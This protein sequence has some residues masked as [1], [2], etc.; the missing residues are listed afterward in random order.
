VDTRCRFLVICVVEQELRRISN[1]A[2]L[3]TTLYG[4]PEY[5]TRQAYQQIRVQTIYIR[6]GII[7]SYKKTANIMRAWLEYTARSSERCAS[8][9]MKRHSAI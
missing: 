4:T 9:V 6:H 3:R 1:V 2:Q 5:G 7:M 8:A